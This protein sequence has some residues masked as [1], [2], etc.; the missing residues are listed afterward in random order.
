MKVK[1]EESKCKKCKALEFAI[2]EKGDWINPCFKLSHLGLQ[3]FTLSQS[4]SCRI[5][6]RKKKTKS[7][8]NLEKNLKI[9]SSFL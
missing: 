5:S 9:T 8:K 6:R 1:Q 7:T 4:L 3:A 2:E